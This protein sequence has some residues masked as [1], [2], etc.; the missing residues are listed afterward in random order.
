[1]KNGILLLTLAL[2][3]PG[4]AAGPSLSELRGGA[5]NATFVQQGRE[6]VQLGF[7]V[8]DTSS[9][10]ATYGSGV[11]TQLGG[12]Y[13]WRDLEQ[14]GRADV[15]KRAPT[16]TDV[17]RWLYNRHT[18][19]D[20]TSTALMPKLAT[21]WG[22]PYE[23]S[24][25]RVVDLRN[26][27]DQ[28]GRFSAFTPAT[29]LVIVYSV[30][31]LRLTERFTVGNAILAGVTFGTNTKNV[32][33]EVETSYRVYKRDPA[34]GAHKRVWLGSCGV[35]SM[36]MTTDFPFPEVVKSREKAKQL[37]DEASAKTIELC[38]KHLGTLAENERKLAKQ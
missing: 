17:M 14:G 29:D 19:V 34:S 30:Q 3:M 13:V 25:L 36:Y 35:H 4:C 6:P 22:V 27:E 20:R 2:L 33:A 21:L 38:T 18:L 32:T 31:N 8:V 11:S 28:D 12:G 1:M 37:W 16:A 26:I 23:P 15:E 24:T 9:F 7:G 5:R 10:W